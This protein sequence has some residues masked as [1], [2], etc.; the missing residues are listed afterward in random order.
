[1]YCP[2]QTTLCPSLL[3]SH[4]STT[5][6]TQ[7]VTKSSSQSQ[8]DATQWMTE[9]TQR[10]RSGTQRIGCADTQLA[11]CLLLCLCG[12]LHLCFPMSSVVPILL[13]IP[14]LIRGNI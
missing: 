4:C 8:C 14:M 5:V 10:L 12:S 7:S 9:L 11:V 1:M 3:L 2:G 6:L 13:I